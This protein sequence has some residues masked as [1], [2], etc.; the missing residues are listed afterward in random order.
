MSAG[1]PFPARG[2]LSR[3]TTTT[4]AASISGMLKTRTIVVS[5][6]QSVGS[7]SR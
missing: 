2:L 6:D 5:R 3:K 1:Q 4:V 7:V